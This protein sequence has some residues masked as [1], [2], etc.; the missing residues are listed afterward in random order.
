MYLPL[1]SSFPLFIGGMIALVV[2][3]RMKRMNI[4]KE[5]STLRMQKGTLIACGL[6]AGSAIIDVV[7]AIPFS[8]MQSPD[9]LQIVGPGW[10]NV[11]VY[12]GILSTLFLAWWINYRVTSSNSE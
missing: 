11:G 8:I 5:E 10:N 12:L 9:A 2:Q 7:L 3:I 6:V 1:S 4:P